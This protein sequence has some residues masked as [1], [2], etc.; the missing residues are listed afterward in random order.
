MDFNCD[1]FHCDDGDCGPPGSCRVEA[2][3]RAFALTVNGGWV[4]GEI[5]EMATHEFFA[6]DAVAGQEYWMATSLISLADTVMY[7]QDNDL[8]QIAQND[9]AGRGTRASLITWTCERTGHYYLKVR[10]YNPVRTGTFQIQVANFPLVV[11]GTVMCTQGNQILRS[12]TSCSG[13][14]GDPCIYICLP[15]YSPSG[16]HLCDSD[17]VYSGGSCA[18][19]QCADATLENS[20]TTCQGSTG[21]TCTYFCDPG[22]TPMGAH[23]CQALG[24]FNGGQCSP[25]ICLSGNIIDNSPTVCRGSV[26]DACVYTCNGGYSPEGVHVCGVDGSFSGGACN[27]APCTSGLEIANSPT[28]CSGNAGDSCLYMCDPGFI[29]FG[30]HECGMNGVFTGGACAEENGCID[31]TCSSGGD[32]SACVDQPAPAAGYTCSCSQG[33][34]DDG[35]TCAEVDGCMGHMCAVGGD[36]AAV[37]VDV[38]AGVVGSS[39]NGAYSCLCGVGYEDVSGICTGLN[40]CDYAQPCQFDGVCEALPDPNL[41]PNINEVQVDGIEGLTTYQL[42]LTTQN[43]AVNIYA[44]YADAN[45]P[46][47]RFSPAYQSAAPFGANIGGVSPDLFE[48]IPTVQYDSWLTIGLD[49][50]DSTSQLTAAN[51]DFSTWTLDSEMVVED[52]A[53]IVTNPDNGPAG[54]V[55]IA[56]ITAPADSWSVT[57]NAQGR[58][59]TRSVNVVTG[60]VDG[61][62]VATGITFSADGI[63]WDYPTYTC[64]CPI[65]TSGYDC[66]VDVDECASGPCRNGAMCTESSTG[67]VELDAYQC[68]CTT[69]YM[70]GICNWGYSFREAD[71]CSVGGGNCD[72]DVDECAVAVCGN[73]AA[74]LESGVDSRVEA[75]THSCSCQRGFSGGLCDYD[76]EPELSD[77]C[78]VAS[79]GNCDWDVNECSS[80]PCQQDATCVDLSQCEDSPTTN[81]DGSIPTYSPPPAPGA[82]CVPIFDAYACTCAPGFADGI[83]LY[84]FI[85]EYA[86]QCE[87]LQ[88]GN[89]GVDVDECAS[90]PCENGGT[91]SDLS[92]VDGAEPEYDAFYCACA[93]GWAH[94]HCDHVINLCELGENDC[95]EVS[96][97]NRKL[98]VHNDLR[99]PYDFHCRA[100]SFLGSPQKLSKYV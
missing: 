26:G 21:D 3:G 78:T 90:S 32:V 15:G 39:P 51:L 16:V 29:P 79:D 62:W 98:S 48:A 33:F 41:L 46:P 28:V 30:R 69:G 5:A 13:Y 70:N 55:L 49:S 99:S 19:Q 58:T 40:A 8:V 71:Y 87:I 9:N 86:D 72:I 14:N 75:G 2:G 77:D 94:E 38:A 68:S 56:Q 97:C 91:C 11:P 45:T 80:S 10:S 24:V 74:C 27:S 85:S 65:G 57:V 67:N 42:T 60:Q 84:D 50:G 20:I 25:N 73:G 6:F 37:C 83:C 7:L 22:Y 18:P 23:V 93:E 36:R 100:N 4:N 31:H 59:A 76:F 64:T 1:T 92:Q 82:S 52:G 81:D 54:Q 12:L 43:A 53:L 66:E 34:Y 61:D 96:T 63:I 17:G 88:G 89:C 95:N 44:I 35:G 47:M